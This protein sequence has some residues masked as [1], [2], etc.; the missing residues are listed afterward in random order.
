MTV[1]PDL[2]R[3][4]IWS[5]LMQ[6]AS[7]QREALPLTKTDLRAAVNALDDF[8]NT[9]AT[10]INNAIPLP[11]RTA[12][13]AKQKALIVAWVALKRHDVGS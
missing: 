12:L 2:E 5:R 3:S 13:T 11:A 8:L 9:N 1:L 10:A 4:D 7:R 6:D